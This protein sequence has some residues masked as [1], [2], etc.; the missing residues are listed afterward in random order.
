MANKTPHGWIDA[1]VHV[2]T[3]DRVRYPRVLNAQ[4]YPPPHF[5]PDHFLAHAKPNGVTRAVLIQMSFYGSDN[6]YM[7]DSIRAYPGGFSGI[8]II[9]ESAT[10]AAEQMTRLSERGVTGFRI[11][12]GDSPK[13]WLDTTTM[14]EMWRCGAERRLA[15]CPLIDPAALPG[16]DR[17]CSRFPDT[18][19][20]IDHM[21]R[22]GV[23]GVIRDEDVKALCGLS[24]HRNVYVKVSAFYALGRKQ[25]PYTDLIPLI[26]R[27]FEAYGPKRLMWASDCPFQVQGGHTYADSVELITKRLDFLSAVDREWLLGK[28]AE[29]ILF[30]S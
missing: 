23:D 4:D 21:A 10:N 25:P 13:T 15:M 5:T 2:W 7:L 11:T 9:S 12:P 26:R 14:L 8:G 17:M 24:K 6:S 29:S 18:P 30:R 28:T 27:V 16:I 3:D 1:H 22:I 20:V 19:V